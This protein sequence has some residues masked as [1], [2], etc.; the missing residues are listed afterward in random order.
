MRKFDKEY[1]RKKRLNN[2]EIKRAEGKSYRLKH[3]LRAKAC[4][5]MWYG[6]KT[7]K[8]KKQPCRDCEREDTQGHHC[9]YSKPLDVIWLCPIHHKLEHVKM[10]ELS[11]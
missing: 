10:K 11:H 2:P 6:L 8:I 7:G 3:P 5:I 1:Q 4:G 9:D